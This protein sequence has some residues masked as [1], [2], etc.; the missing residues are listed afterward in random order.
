MAIAKD[1]KVDGVISNSEAAM[2]IVAYVAEQLG[3]PGNSVRGIEQLV[4]KTEFRQLQR[5]AG[6]YAPRNFECGTWE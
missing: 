4:S 5:N 1:E 3:L 6:V 2:L